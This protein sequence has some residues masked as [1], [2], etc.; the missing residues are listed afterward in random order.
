M[1]PAAQDTLA[2]MQ[3]ERRL[4][5]LRKI[6]VDAQIRGGWVAFM[7]HALGLSQRD[8]A[9][10]TDLAPATIS[11][12][13]QREQLGTISLAMMRKLAAAMDCELIYAVVPRGSIASLLRERATQKAA[14]LLRN[15]DVHMTLEDQKVRSDFDERV[16][17]LAADL[18]AKGD[19][20]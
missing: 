2:R 10:L 9:K 17:I 15:T 13:E 7:R 11:Q 18:L 20:W 4:A 1:K 16:R 19:V 3:I 8:L 14:R 5:K 12:A 6:A